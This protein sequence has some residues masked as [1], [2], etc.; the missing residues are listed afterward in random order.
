ML[1]MMRIIRK[2]V[3]VVLIAATV[4]CMISCKKKASEFPQVPPPSTSETSEVTEVTET[5]EDPEITKLMVALPYEA[6]TVNYLFKLYYAKNN[7][8]WNPDYSGLTV[9]L[10]YLD[11]INVP[12]SFESVYVPDDGVSSVTLTNWGSTRPD[13]FLVNDLDEAVNSGYCADISDAMSDSMLLTS[14]KFYVGSITCLYKDGALYGVPHYCSI[15]LI[16]GNEDFAPEGKSLNF[17]CTLNELKDYISAIRDLE[18]EDV[19]VFARGYQLIPYITS[20][21]NDNG[22][23]NSYMLESEYKADKDLSQAKLDNVIAMIGEFYDDG[24][25]VNSNPDDS[26]PV[27]SRNCAMWIASSTD[28]SLWSNYYPGKL[29]YAQIPTFEYNDKSIPY[30]TVYPLCVSSTS[31]NID[32]ASDF[33]AF[34][35]LDT[36]AL[37]LIDR[38]ED[39]VGYLPVVTSPNVW[40]IKIADE[41]F[42]YIASVYENEMDNAVYCPKVI[43]NDLYDLI[44]LKLSDC[45]NIDEEE[46]Y[47]LNLADIY[48]N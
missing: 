45:Y 34:I 3:A 27:F 8:Y 17:R 39:K 12:I 26:D 46:L 33:A 23:V 2:L 31:K 40:D 16:Y 47:E 48:G 13:I 20:A 29:Y 35:S 37:L 4:L 42:G 43:N 25:F 19:V 5:S 14:D 36:D 15:P 10:G 41:T 1:D 18:Y 21:K 7:G 9:D 44:E 6:S 38:L 28:L 30:L 32:L 24:T 22:I 11:S